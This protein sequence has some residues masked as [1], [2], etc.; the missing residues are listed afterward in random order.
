MKRKF[1]AVGLAM[2]A[3]VSITCGYMTT[4]MV[5]GPVN[6]TEDEDACDLQDIMESIEDEALRESPAA[7][8]TAFA[9][10]IQDTVSGRDLEALAELCDFPISVTMQDGTSLTVNSREDFITLGKESVFTRSLVHEI[11]IADPA[12]QQIYG[13]GIVM[14]NRN[15]I[16]INRMHGSLAVT[17]FNF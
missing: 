8:L 12:G 5:A 13:N 10:E 9:A 7:E 14:G 4:A 3:V 11:G 16:I 17:G 6:Q 2:T 15:N 1:L